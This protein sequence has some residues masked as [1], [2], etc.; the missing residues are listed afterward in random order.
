MLASIAASAQVT[1]VDPVGANYANKTVSFRVWWN[2]GSRDATHLSKVW[3]WVDYIKVNANNTTA[4][5]TW[6]RAAVS[7]ASP[8][9]SVSYDGSNRQGFWL[10]GSSGSYSA[11]VTVQ[12]NIAETK[13]NWCAYGSDY[14]TNASS[15]NNGTYTFKGTKPFIVNGTTVNNNQ[16]TTTKITSLTDSTGCPGCITIRDF[17]FNSSAVSI[18]CC[19][20]LTAIGSYCRDLVADAASTFTGCGIEIKAADAGTSIWSPDNLCPTGWRWPSVSELTC[21]I[22]NRTDVGGLNTSPA[23]HSACGGTGTTC[24][25]CDYWTNES[26]NATNGRYILSCTIG[27]SPVGSLLNFPKTTC[28]MSVRCVRN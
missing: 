26:Y 20:N 8:T 25:C 28:D 7:A 4:G 3:V 2:A 24:G 19:P 21:I 5:N 14:P 27:S 18:P 15:Y 10:Q 11:T 17:N 1:H 9:A 16:Y 13:F 12:L 6:T 22:N 23:P